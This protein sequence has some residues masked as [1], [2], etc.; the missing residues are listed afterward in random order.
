M[1]R[2]TMNASFQTGGEALTKRDGSSATLQDITLLDVN[3]GSD[4]QIYLLEEA[5]C[6]PVPAPFQNMRTINMQRRQLV[7]SSRSVDLYTSFLYAVTSPSKTVK[8]FFHV[9]Y[10]TQET[11]FHRDIQTP[12]RE[13]KIRRAADYF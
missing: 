10:Q 4:H 11:V 1:V 3:K 12:R 9:I 6:C 2:C 5:K 13:L 8:T 7:A